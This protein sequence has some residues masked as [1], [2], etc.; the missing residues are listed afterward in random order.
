[1]ALSQNLIDRVIHIPYPPLVAPTPE[2]TVVSML[3]DAYTE[4]G[5]V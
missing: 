5:T 3:R 1:M 4:F 2:F